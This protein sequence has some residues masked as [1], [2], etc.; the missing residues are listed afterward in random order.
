[1]VEGECG[2]RRVC[3]QHGGVARFLH[4]LVL[5]LVLLVP[6][7]VAGASSL[8]GASSAPPSTAPPSTGFV[9]STLDLSRCLSALPPPECDTEHKGDWHIYAVMGV[10]VAGLGFIGWRIGRAIRARDRALDPGPR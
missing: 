10:L 3:W 7:P 9:D 2:S 4:A 8:V 6:A 5:V 1:M